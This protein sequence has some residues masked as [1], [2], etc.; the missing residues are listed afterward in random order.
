M[1]MTEFY[2][3]F[4]NE[5]VK[6]KVKLTAALSSAE[7]KKVYPEIKDTLESIKKLIYFKSQSKEGKLLFDII[8]ANVAV[9]E[10]NYAKALFL[11]EN[12]LR[13][14]AVTVHDSLICL[15][16]L[17]STFVRVRNFIKAYEVNSKM[18]RLWPRKPD[19]LQMHYGISKSGLYASM[20]FLNDAVK[21]RRAEFL[22]KNLVH[23]TD[24]LASFYNDMGVYFNRQKKSDSAIAYFLMIDHLISNKKYPAERK[25]HY[26]FVKA[27]AKGNLGLSYYNKGDIRKTIPL[28]E[29]D[30]YYSLKY[31]RLESAFNSYLLMIECYLNLNN[32]RIAGLYLD[33]A[34]RIVKNH[35]H[36]L[37]PRL[38]LLFSQSKFYQKTGDYKT[39]N[40]YFEKYFMLK[41]SISLMEKEQNMLNTEVAFK[42]EQ[43]DAELS[44]KT[45]VLE[46]QKLNEAKQ[47]SFR[48]YALAGILLLIAIIVILILNNRYS[49]NREKQL[50][51]KNEKINQQNIQIE[52]SLREKEVL[53]KE[54]HHR[55]KNNLQIITSM[56][57]L[58]ITKEEGRGTEAILREAKQRIDSIALTHQMLYQNDD[59][60]N[61][62]LGDYIEKLVR[63]IEYSLPATGIRLETEIKDG[64]EKISIDHAIPLGLLVNEL[65]TN[66][67]KH[68]FPG[69]E[70]GVIRV[71]LNEDYNNVML[72]VSDSGIGLPDNYLDNERKSMGMDLILILAEQLE[73]ELITRV[74]N[75]TSFELKIPKTKIFNA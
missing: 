51:L 66:A 47:K 18:E 13:N 67:Y 72:M 2:E 38:N 46:R 39:S 59:L 54:I 8:E 25:T 26:E 11:A 29:E 35:L 74:E 37:T 33:S 63:Q 55:V 49:K 10:K 15:S 17:K 73:A 75:G 20:G 62:L 24:R 48:A 56:L 30:I 44:E 65:L 31:E 27:L 34:E 61:I 6:G 60:S 28:L 12:S 19:S 32:S 41:D 23:D 43:K 4:N 16:I 45:R 71:V 22:E 70:S 50:Y 36:E 14:H 52:Q 42:I 57:S 58:Q 5:G 3:K 53:I 9:G 64:S 68:A 7:L 69:R 1:N 40:N 21:A